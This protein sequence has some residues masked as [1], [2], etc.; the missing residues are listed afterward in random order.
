MEAISLFTGIGGFDIAFK[1]IFDC[2]P[3]AMCEVNPN[4]RKV[5]SARFS[6]V[7][8][9]VDIKNYTPDQRW[10]YLSGIVYGGF[11]CKDTSNAGLRLGLSGDESRLWL[12]M[13]RI[14]YE[15]KPKYVLI[16]NPEGLVTRGLRAVLGGLRMAGYCWED[17]QIISAAELGAPHRR[18]RLF[19]LA[20]AN[21]LSKRVRQIS[22]C[23]AEQIGSQIKNRKAHY[24]RE[25]A[26]LKS[27]VLPHGIPEWLGRRHLDGYWESKARSA[28]NDPETL[29]YCKGRTECI[30]LYGKA[31]TPEQAAIAFSRVK[32]I[33]SQLSIK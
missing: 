5:L 26:T 33:N 2:H 6:D 25:K 11:P 24:Q 14:I 21:H 13:L 22:P 31:V 23:W 9:Y 16:E 18:K 12:E 10:E 29:K 15:V 28:I 4:A 1:E 30:N 27:D 32:F 20:Y 7:P 3:I 17:P 8:L 19:I